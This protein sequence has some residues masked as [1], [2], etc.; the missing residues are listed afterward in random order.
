[1]TNYKSKTCADCKHH[2]CINICTTSKTCDGYCEL[3]RH[4]KN[5]F[6]ARCKKFELGEYFKVMR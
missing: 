5:C 6:G 2:T 1:M 3:N 4:H